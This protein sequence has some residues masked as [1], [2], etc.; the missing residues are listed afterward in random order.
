MFLVKTSLEHD[1]VEADMVG[2]AARSTIVPN[3]LHSVVSNI[4]KKEPDFK[5]INVY[6]KNYQ[7]PKFS[8]LALFRLP[9]ICSISASRKSTRI[10]TFPSYKATV[11]SIAILYFS[12]K[13]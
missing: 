9:I 2:V 8:P 7:R 4:Y 10:T 1:L 5:R 6:I 11:P 12:L 3:I 13:I